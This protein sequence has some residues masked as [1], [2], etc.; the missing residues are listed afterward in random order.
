MTAM[1]RFAEAVRHELARMR[2]SISPSFT[3]S[4]IPTEQ[5]KRIGYYPCDPCGACGQGKGHRQHA[6][7]FSQ[8]AIQYVFDALL[9]KVS[10][11]KRKRKRNGSN[12]SGESLKRLARANNDPQWIDVEEKGNCGCNGDRKS[13]WGLAKVG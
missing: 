5:T 2:S 10:R 1:T 8:K 12:S 9:F 4:L 11:A 6:V 7:N 3:F 13:D